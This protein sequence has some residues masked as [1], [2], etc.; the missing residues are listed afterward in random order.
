MSERIRA[1]IESHEDGFFDK[2]DRA[3]LVRIVTTQSAEGSELRE[4]FSSMPEPESVWPPSANTLDGLN[5]WRDIRNWY[6]HTRHL[7]T[8]ASG[9][10]PNCPYSDAPC[11]CT[12]D[13]GL[14]AKMC[15]R[16]QDQ[17]DKPADSRQDECL[18]KHPNPDKVPYKA[19]VEL[20][21][22]LERWVSS[23]NTGKSDGVYKDTKDVLYGERFPADSRLRCP[24]CHGT[25][26]TVINKAIGVEDCPLCSDDSEQ[27][28]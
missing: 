23:W 10:R 21:N 4:A 19:D 15:P 13:N 28:F 24:E 1:W 8:S 7:A 11:T 27:K 2:G 22:L 16:Y 26:K 6:Y 12:Q 5:L 3:E 14:P 17:H 20:L 9:K 25:G 18:I